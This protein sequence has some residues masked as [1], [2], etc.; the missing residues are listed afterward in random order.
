MTFKYQKEALT[1][2]CWSRDAVLLGS[3]FSFSWLLWHLCDMGLLGYVVLHWFLQFGLEK[4]TRATLTWLQ[5]E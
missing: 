3:V 4:V 1:L 5:L 2:L